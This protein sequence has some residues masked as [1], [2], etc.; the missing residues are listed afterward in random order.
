[1]KGKLVGDRLLFFQLRLV[2]FGY[3][4]LQRAPDWL[5]P[6]ARK[7]GSGWEGL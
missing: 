7:T 5:S 4:A 2:L 1:M 6:R 3:E